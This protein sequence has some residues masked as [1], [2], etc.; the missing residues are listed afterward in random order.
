MKKTFFGFFSILL[1]SFLVSC[2]VSSSSDNNCS[3]SFESNGANYIETQTI[4]KGEKAVEPSNLTRRN[5]KFVGWYKQ[6]FGFDFA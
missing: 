5:D 3:V 6:H 4:R 1:V 2:G